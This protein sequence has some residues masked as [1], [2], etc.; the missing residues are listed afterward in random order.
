MALLVTMDM[1]KNALFL[2]LFL[3]KMLSASQIFESQSSGS[4][5]LD[6]SS[7][8][9]SFDD[10]MI[11][12]IDEQIRGANEES[13]NSERPFNMNDNIIN[14]Y[15][16]KDSDSNKIEANLNETKRLENNFN[17]EIVLFSTSSSMADSLIES[18]KKEANEPEVRDSTS[19]R[20]ETTRDGS[21]TEETE[22]EFNRGKISDTEETLQDENKKSK[23]ATVAPIV[24]NESEN[25][26]RVLY[27]NRKGEFVS[28]LEDQD[29]PC[30]GCCGPPP[31]VK[32]CDTACPKCLGISP[33]PPP[34]NPLCNNNCPGGFCG[35]DCPC[36]D[37]VCCF[38]DTVFVTE[39][40]TC[41]NYLFSTTISTATQT[42]ISIIL[43]TVSTT[44]TLTFSITTDFLFT[45]I[46]I[47]T[48]TGTSTSTLT[49]TSV[50]SS[51]FSTTFYFF[52]D[53]TT[54]T[55][56]VI[57]TS[58]IGTVVVT[59]FTTVFTSFIPTQAFSTITTSTG[60]LTLDDTVTVTTTVTTTD[61]ITVV[62]TLV[63]NTPPP[64]KRMQP[65]W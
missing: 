17:E 64:G 9:P 45:S 12:Y 65:R 27:R 43:T 6:I 48:V 20:E 57:T 18:L 23:N 63:I 56:L 25:F 3:L 41:L 49:T 26:V 33:G 47:S 19:K 44:S 16:L 59:L 15:F 46:D 22:L 58:S 30:V 24:P 32:C 2:V 29:C 61:T 21:T 36:D 31:P 50:S 40:S 42:A 1:R 14:D 54:Q 62:P 13:S 38:I 51:I 53:T 10:S 37:C 11:K 60:T 28:K 35:N 52:T 5:T 34:L 39:T 8:D 55:G 4:E 7:E